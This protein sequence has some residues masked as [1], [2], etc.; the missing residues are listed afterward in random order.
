MPPASSQTA[1]S[2]SIGLVER[3]AVDQVVERR[4]VHRRRI[5]SADSVGELG[6]PQPPRWPDHTAVSLNPAVIHRRADGIVLHRIDF[7]EQQR[8][9]GV[10]VSRRDRPFLVAGRRARGRA[11]WSPPGFHTVPSVPESTDACL[12]RAGR[13]PAAGCSTSVSRRGSRRHFRGERLHARALRWRRELRAAGVRDR[14]GDAPCALEWSGLGG[15]RP[16]ASASPRPPPSWPTITSEVGTLLPFANGR[17]LVRLMVRAW[18][19]VRNGD[20]HRRPSGGRCDSTERRSR[21]EPVTTAPQ[22]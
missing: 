21:C 12:I 18:P 6:L 3:H 16:S 5:A 9:F 2:S 19:G 14:P 17:L 1:S 20:H 10:V 11:Q 15:R 7:A 13:C 22:L 4:V 8:N